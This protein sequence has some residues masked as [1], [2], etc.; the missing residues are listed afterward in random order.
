VDGSVYERTG[1]N[2]LPG[3]IIAANDERLELPRRC[4]WTTQAILHTRGSVDF[5]R[6]YLGLYVPNPLLLARATP[7]LAGLEPPA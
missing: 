1:G 2:I 5:F 3:E 6:T 7:V 4:A